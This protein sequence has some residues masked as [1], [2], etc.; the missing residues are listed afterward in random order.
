[1]T[2]TL[3]CANHPKRETT[4][5]CNRCEKPIC[6][7]CAIHTPTGYR[8]K[9]CV[10][11]Q[12][13]N[14]ENA[15]WSDYLFGFLAAAILSGIGSAIVAVISNWFYGLMVLFFAP[16]A[17][18]LIARGVQIVTR[19]RRSRSLFIVAAVGVIMG[20]IPAILGGIATLL[21]VF[22]N[23]EYYTNISWLWILLPFIWQ[24]V[25]LVIAAPAVYARLSGI[26][27]K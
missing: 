22:S 26:T 13:K 27:F 15:I 7:K 20:V 8:C 1:M 2:E 9:E 11:E 18:T 21:F 3:Y 5:R 17:A 12:K 23:I 24:V 16:F 10:N 19:R 14:F 25:Y 4:L 6:T